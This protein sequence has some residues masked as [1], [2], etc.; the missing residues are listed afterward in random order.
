MR[1]QPD[2]IRVLHVED[3][4]TDA[5]L[6]QLFLKKKGYNNL[7]FTVVP[8]AEKGLEVLEREKFDVVLSDYKMPGMNGIEFLEELRKRGN[9]VPFI[10]FTGKGEEKVAI[11]AINK[12]ANRYIKK[13]ENPRVLFDMLARY[14]HEVVEERRRIEESERRIKELEEMDRRLQGASKRL[15]LRR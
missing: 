9:N 12:G 7:D 5:E 2:V 14:I 8:S 1:N 13:D 6:T 10:I 15:E 3:D 4:A 11:E